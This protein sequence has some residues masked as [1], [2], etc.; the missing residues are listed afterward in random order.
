MK[1]L[2]RVWIRIF[3]DVPVSTKPAEVRMGSGKGAPEF[4]VCRV[5][6]GRIMFEIDGVPETLAREAFELA[7]AKLPIKTTHRGPPGRWSELTMKAEELR[8]KTPDQLKG[9]LVQLQKEQFNL[10]FQRA[11]GQLENTARVRAVRRDIA[12]IKTIP[13][14]QGARPGSRRGRGNAQARPARHRGQRQGRQDRDRRGRAPR[15]A[16]G[17]QEVHH[18]ARSIRGA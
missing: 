18:V 7:A 9:D 8:H 10:R 17:L 6:P 11:S 14:A 15:H 4:W 12:R 5:H 16:P 1:R 2:G 3:P 13:R